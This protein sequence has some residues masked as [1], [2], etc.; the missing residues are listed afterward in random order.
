[1]AAGRKDIHKDAKK[2]VKGDPRIN[3]KGQ[4]VKNFTQH[5]K[6]LKDKG[7]TAPTRQEYFEM[8]G[9]LLVMTKPDIES[10]EKDDEKPYWIRLI[11]KDLQNESQRVRL[12]QDQRD[13]LYGK[14]A[15]STDITSGGEKIKMP[16]VIS[17]ENFDED[18]D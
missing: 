14:A 6:E 4:P 10:F 11:A 8:I 3:R 7:Y 17:F 9:L 5:I 18:Q 15:Q 2:F 13:W 12:M 1:M 16:T